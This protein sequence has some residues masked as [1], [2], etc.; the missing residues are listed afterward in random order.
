MY[1]GTRHQIG[2]RVGFTTAK[3]LKSSQSQKILKI[4]ALSGLAIQYFLVLATFPR[5]LTVLIPLFHCLLSELPHYVVL[6]VLL[7]VM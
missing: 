1:L 6:N 2:Y 4:L 5:S 3:L 7:L